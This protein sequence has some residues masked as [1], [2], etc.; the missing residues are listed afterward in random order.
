MAGEATSG[1][2]RARLGRAGEELAAAHLELHGCTIVDRNRRTPFGEI[3]LL[4]RDGHE[5]VIVEVKARRSLACGDGAEA[6]DGRKRLRLRRAA[7]FLGLDAG[8]L[9]FDVIAVAL[10][11]GSADITW[12]KGAF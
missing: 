7:Q 8:R 9:R 2:R 12:L 10:R 4:V 1:H 6:V 3:D 11:A 5:T